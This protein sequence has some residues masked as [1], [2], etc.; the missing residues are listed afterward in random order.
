MIRDDGKKKGYV[1]PED[2]FQKKLAYYN[3]TTPYPPEAFIE[4]LVDLS[5]R[6]RAEGGVNLG[7]ML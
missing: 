1:I 7:K 3:A 6:A 5:K 4:R 2:E